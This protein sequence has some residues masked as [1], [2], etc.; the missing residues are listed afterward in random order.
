MEGVSETSTQSSVDSARTIS[1]QPLWNTRKASKLVGTTN[2]LFTVLREL[3]IV[4][5]E[6]ESVNRS[7]NNSDDLA[8]LRT[9][10]FVFGSQFTNPKEVWCLTFDET[11]DKVETTDDGHVRR[12]PT[13]AQVSESCIR[14]L[15]QA[16]VAET[17]DLWESAYAGERN[18]HRLSERLDSGDR[19]S[20]MSFRSV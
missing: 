7:T 1:S 4:L 8:P 13:K 2:D 17:S 3:F 15:V 16:L 11:L 9:I 19:S 10:A 14:R 6:I 5:A 12:R 18:L 20:S